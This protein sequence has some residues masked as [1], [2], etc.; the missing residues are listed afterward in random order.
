MSNLN[1]RMSPYLKL[2]QMNYLW[3]SIN[4]IYIVSFNIEKYI[5][6]N[7]KKVERISSVVNVCQPPLRPHLFI[8]C[9]QLTT[10]AALSQHTI[11]PQLRRPVNAEK[12]KICTKLYYGI[13]EPPYR[14][15][16]I[17]FE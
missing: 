10:D 17:Y 8:S 15:D 12:W 16:I 2:K 7:L 1:R 13:G 3:N 11:P 6:L 9:N 5:Q 4:T 14:Y